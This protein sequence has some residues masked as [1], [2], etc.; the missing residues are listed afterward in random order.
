VSKCFPVTSHGPGFNVSPWLA[1]APRSRTQEG[2]SKLNGGASDT[3]PAMFGL[4]RF[5]PLTSP[6]SGVSSWDTA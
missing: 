2:V 6:G 3:A 5:G 4:S 1:P